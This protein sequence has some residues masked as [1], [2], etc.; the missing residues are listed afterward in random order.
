MPRRSDNANQSPASVADL[1]G[2]SGELTERREF[3]A[4]PRPCRCWRC[5][6]ES[7]RKKD[8]LTWRSVQR[9]SFGVDADWCAIKTTWHDCRYDSQGNILPEPITESEFSRRVGARKTNL[10]GRVGY[11]NSTK[12]SLKVHWH[13]PDVGRDTAQVFKGFNRPPH[14]IALAKECEREIEAFFQTKFQLSRQLQSMHSRG[15]MVGVESTGLEMN[16]VEKDL[17]PVKRYLKGLQPYLSEA[18]TVPLPAEVSGQSTTPTLPAQ[19]SYPAARTTASYPKEISTRS[20]SSTTPAQHGH[21]LARTSASPPSRSSDPI[22]SGPKTF[23]PP[24]TV[25][26]NW[27]APR[28]PSDFHERGEPTDP[29][30][31]VWEA[32]DTWTSSQDQ[33]YGSRP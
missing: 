8:M 33:A 3:Q 13:P 23:F 5:S 6:D 28:T 4:D 32:P 2:T 21:V 20:T 16:R 17:E 26:L 19:V 31:F 9:Q 11:L 29:A 24:G 18:T 7:H 15:D 30:G 27:T 25:P 10:A 1:S 12:N 14:P 22:V